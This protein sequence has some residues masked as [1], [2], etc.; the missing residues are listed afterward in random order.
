L[1]SEVE[2]INAGHKSAMEQ[3]YQAIKDTAIALN[4]AKSAHHRIDDLKSSICW[5]LGFSVT[6]V[7]VFASV[8]TAF[9][10]KGS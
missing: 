6:V 9:L 3:V 2:K 10:S 7:G 4:T 1:T 8:L 5:T